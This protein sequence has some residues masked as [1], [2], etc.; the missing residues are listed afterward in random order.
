MASSIWDEAGADSRVESALGEGLGRLSDMPLLYVL[1][2][3]LRISP[4]ARYVV[5]HCLGGS[6][7]DWVPGSECDGRRILGGRARGTPRLKGTRPQEL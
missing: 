2:G 3:S 5:D 7:W 1:N 4:T 6:S